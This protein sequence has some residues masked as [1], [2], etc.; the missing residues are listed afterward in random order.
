MT[1]ASLGKQQLRGHI[2]EII[3]FVAFNS[4][5]ITVQTITNTDF[6]FRMVAVFLTSCCTPHFVPERS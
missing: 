1:S 3:E 6:F 2:P 5:E 4:N